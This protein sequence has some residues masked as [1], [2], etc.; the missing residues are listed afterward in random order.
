MGVEWGGEEEDRAADDGECLRGFSRGR[1]GFLRTYRSCAEERVDEDPREPDD[2]H[3]PDQPRPLHI[4]HPVVPVP[5]AIPRGHERVDRV[6]VCQRE[7]ERLRCCG[8]GRVGEGLFGEN[9][10]RIERCRCRREGWRRWQRY[11]RYKQDERKKVSV[12][13][14]VDD[15]HCSRPLA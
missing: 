5:P 11:E 10:G 3:R 14:S 6:Q 13:A 2:G 8:I 4:L 7:E 1:E 12:R 9:Q 15:E